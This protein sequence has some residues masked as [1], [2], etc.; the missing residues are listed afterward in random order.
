[1]RLREW[2]K[3]EALQHSSIAV[4][5]RESQIR[6][7]PEY[8]NKQFTLLFLQDMNGSLRSPRDRCYS[9]DCFEFSKAQ[10]IWMVRTSKS[11][12]MLSGSGEKGAHIL[13]IFSALALNI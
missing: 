3:G 6:R 12:L 4:R 10:V 9:R 7:F 1:M 13:T 11:C 5:P 8:F 2:R